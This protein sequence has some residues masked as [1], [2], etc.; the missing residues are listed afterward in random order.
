MLIVSCSVEMYL[1]VKWLYDCKAQDSSVY[2]SGLQNLTWSS[3]NQ[4]ETK[5]EI[6]C[7][8]HNVLDDIARSR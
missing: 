2:N 8:C 3:A 1:F 5:T 6:F 4:K 7:S